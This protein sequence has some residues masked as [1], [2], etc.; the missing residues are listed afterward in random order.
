MG[1]Y[2]RPPDNVKKYMDNFMNFILFDDVA[3]AILLPGGNN[4]E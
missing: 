4:T 3:G 2:H 1:K